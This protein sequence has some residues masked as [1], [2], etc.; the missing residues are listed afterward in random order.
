[1]EGERCT[2]QTLIKT[3][4][5]LYYK[6]TSLKMINILISDKVAFNSK[7]II[8]GK[9]GH[10]IIMQCTEY[11]IILNVN[12][13]KLRSLPQKKDESKKNKKVEKV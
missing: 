9:E 4:I 2:K 12:I 10:D 13:P 7:N 5:I 8:I 11:I 1:M 6:V 3:K